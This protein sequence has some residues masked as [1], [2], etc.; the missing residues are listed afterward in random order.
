MSIFH[1]LASYRPSERGLSLEDFFT[2]LWAY[3]LRKHPPLVDRVLQVLGVPPAPPYQI[4]T[5]V[6]YGA[7]ALEGSRMQCRPDLRVTTS[8]G[9]VLIEHKIEASQ[10]I[11][12]VEGADGGGYTQLERYLAVAPEASVALISLGP[13]DIRPN[14]RD[15]PRYRKPAGREHFV[16]HSLFPAVESYA[17]DAGAADPFIVELI[18]FMEELGMR[19]PREGVGIIPAANL[20]G[21]KAERKALSL[22][23]RPTLN[24]ALQQGWIKTHSGLDLLLQREHGDY[25]QVHLDMRYREKEGVADGFLKARLRVLEHRAEGAK[26]LM[27]HLTQAGYQASMQRARATRE[28]CIDIICLTLRSRTEYIGDGDPTERLTRF[29]CDAMSAFHWFLGLPPYVCADDTLD[30]SRS[31]SSVVRVGS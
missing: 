6:A 1:R 25:A 31:G 21:I 2:E 13:L 8:Q 10:H 29:A 20:D 22:W 14:V 18:E 28:P 17:Q 24:L 16:W 3:V 15:N 27:N 30:S 9:I 23:W 4:E 12:S 5:Q 11:E 7:A 26:S 19:T